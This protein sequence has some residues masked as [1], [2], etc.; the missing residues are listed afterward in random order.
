MAIDSLLELSD[1]RTKAQTLADLQAAAE[2]LPELERQQQ[3]ALAAARLEENAARAGADLSVLAQQYRQELAASNAELEDLVS[4]FRSV[5]AKRKQVASLGRE[6]LTLSEH[7][8]M[9]GLSS[10]PGID[11]NST[12]GTRREVLVSLSQQ[13]LIDQGDLW[14]LMLFEGDQSP[15]TRVLLN[16]LQVVL[17]GA[18]TTRSKF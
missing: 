9:P 2:R 4:R 15:E 10:Q 12:P 14:P 6:L 18:V 11:K 1:A 13:A 17:P 3:D 7:V 16:A 8:A 5:V